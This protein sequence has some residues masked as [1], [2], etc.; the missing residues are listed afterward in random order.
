MAFF[1]TPS[2]AQSEE[3]QVIDNIEFLEAMEILEDGNWDAVN[4]DEVTAESQEK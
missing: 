4:S 1:G 2:I 3:Q